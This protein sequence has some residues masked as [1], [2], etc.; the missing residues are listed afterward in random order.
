MVG[1]EPGQFTLKRA[2]LSTALIAV[3]CFGISL[4]TRG[5]SHSRPINLYTLTLALFAQSC[6]MW[7]GAGLGTLFNKWR[8]GALI[9]WAVQ[10][11]AFLGYI[12]WKSR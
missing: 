12:T 9:G 5:D 1:M 10:V 3:G 6:L 8:T 2:M 11:V 7:I 4:W